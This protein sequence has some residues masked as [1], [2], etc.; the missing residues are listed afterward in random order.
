MA[1]S[2]QECAEWQKY[3]EEV[4][5]VLEATAHEDLVMFLRTSTTM[6]VSE[7]EEEV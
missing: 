7:T 3:D 1:Q 4:D 2:L 5:I 6:G